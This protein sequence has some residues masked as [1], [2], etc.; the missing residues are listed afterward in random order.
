MGTDAAFRHCA[1]IARRHYENFPVASLA[2]PRPMRR[3][4]VVIYAFSRT[5]DDLADEGE[6]P[7]AARLEALEAYGAGLDAALEGRPA[8]DPVLTATAAAIRRHALPPRLFHD[9]LHAFR[10]DVTRRRYGTHEEV[11]DY[12]RHS[13]NPVGRLLLHLAG[14]DREE[15]LRDSDAVCT[16]L[17]LVNF[18]QDLH[19]DYARHGRIYLPADEMARHGVHEGH[20]RDRVTDPGMR[21]LLELQLARVRAGLCAGVPLGRR[22]GGRFGLEI[23][24][25]V[26]GG[27][28]V[29]ELLEAQGGDLYAR[30]RLRGRDRALL[31]W[32]AL[33]GLGTVD[34]QWCRAQ[35]S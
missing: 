2:L 29:A 9:L 35:A 3:A 11:L 18:L 23:R 34:V 21:A 19:Q 12:C 5:A 17:Q 31:L 10:Q 8:G 27:L 26:A 28:R 7:A 14:E 32:Q 24:M 4:A 16:A 25:I 20:L 13:A 15:N 30:P 33:R 1:D 22:L 6:L